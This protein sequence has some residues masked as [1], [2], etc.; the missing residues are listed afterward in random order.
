MFCLVG[1]LASASLMRIPHNSLPRAMR[2]SPPRISETWMD[3]SADLP[4]EKG[5]LSGAG[6]GSQ[7]NQN[8]PPSNPPRRTPPVISNQPVRA[9]GSSGREV[10]QIVTRAK[11]TSEDGSISPYLALGHRKLNHRINGIRTQPPSRPTPTDQWLSGVEVP[12]HH[13]K[14]R[15]TKLVQAR[16]TTRLAK[17]W[18]RVVS[19]LAGVVLTLV[20]LVTE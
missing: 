17:R 3:T 8:Q 10:R 12:S 15:A 7:R 1:P 11:L 16:R 6:T 4:G 19:I 9:S 2:T 5:S 14:P 13:M 18:L 20:V